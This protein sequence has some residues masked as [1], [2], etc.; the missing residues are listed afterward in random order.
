MATSLIPQPSPFLKCH[1][2]C[3]A[4]LI[5]VLSIDTSPAIPFELAALRTECW[6]CRRKFY[7]QTLLKSSED[8]KNTVYISNGKKKKR[9]TH[10][11]SCKQTV[12][13]MTMTGKWLKKL[14]D[15]QTIAVLKCEKLQRILRAG[16]IIRHKTAQW[17]ICVHGSACSTTAAEDSRVSVIPSAYNEKQLQLPSYYQ[18]WATKEVGGEKKSARFDK[19]RFVMMTTGCEFGRETT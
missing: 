7:I 10:P 9:C 16:Y 1:A 12:S 13:H 2:L 15:I 4:L 17:K 5:C 19:K 18:I 11:C 8:V 3:A 6:R 14:F